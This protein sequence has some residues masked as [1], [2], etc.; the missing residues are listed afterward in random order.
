MN[1]PSPNVVAGIDVGKSKL[2]V[3]LL[4]CVVDQVFRNDQCGRRA[5]RNWLPRHGVTRAVYE[6]LGRYHRNLQQCLAD[7]GIETV[8]VNPLRSRRFAEALGRVAKNDRVGAGMLAR[9]GL[10]DELA[11][12]FPRAENLRQL[13][14]LLALRRKLPDQLG[15]LC[16]L[17]AELDPQTADYAAAAREA[18]R[19]GIA[20]CERRML[21]NTYDA[22]LAKGYNNAISQSL[23]P[24]EASSGLS[25]S[26]RVLAYNR[27]NAFARPD[28]RIFVRSGLM[29]FVQNEAQLAV[30]LGPRSM[31]LAYPSRNYWRGAW[32]RSGMRHSRLATLG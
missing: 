27:P 26:F 28:G 15:T 30:A 19:A 4:H 18:L 22:P 10:L 2:D 5:V 16:G 3:H 6:P 7:A 8:L 25:F 13:R 23:L 17:C 29:A 9:F 32:H 24:E 31:S 20:A 12:T 11:A 21:E 1:E 14:D